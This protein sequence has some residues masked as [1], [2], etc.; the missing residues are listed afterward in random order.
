M[1]EMVSLRHHLAARFAPFD[2]GVADAVES[3]IQ[4]FK[5]GDPSDSPIPIE[6]QHQQTRT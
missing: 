2:A 6:I 5:S 1:A 4:G 3:L